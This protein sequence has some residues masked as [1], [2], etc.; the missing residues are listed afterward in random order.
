VVSLFYQST[1]GQRSPADHE[2]ITLAL[3]PEEKAA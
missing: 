2:K 3:T 1:L